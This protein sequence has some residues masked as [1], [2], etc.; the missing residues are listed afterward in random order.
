[1]EKSIKMVNTKL[2]EIP[3]CSPGTVG[4]CENMCSNKSWV[5]THVRVKYEQTQPIG[6]ER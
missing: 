5:L 1:M 3:L 2:V 4:E 6:F